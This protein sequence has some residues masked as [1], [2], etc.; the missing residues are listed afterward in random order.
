MHIHTY[1]Y[2]Y[3]GKLERPHCDLSGIMVNKGNHP[4]MAFI[5]V[6]GLLLFTYIYT[7]IR[8]Y[9]YIYTYIYIYELKPVSFC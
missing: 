5:Q 7:H 8:M 6:S 3:W 4:Q 1:I 2:K 9:I